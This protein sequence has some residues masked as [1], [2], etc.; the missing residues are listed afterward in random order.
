MESE[1]DNA[2]S[3]YRARIAGAGR[4]LPPTRLT[5]ADLMASTAHR[6]HVDLERLT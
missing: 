2:T 3:P 1:R 4:H 6:T 5:T